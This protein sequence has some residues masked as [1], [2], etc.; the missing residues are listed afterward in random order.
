MTTETIPAHDPHPRKRVAVH[1]AEMSYIDVGE[2]DPVVF[3]HGNPTSSYFWRNVIPHVAPAARCLAPDLIG[4]GDSD[5]NP[6]GSYRFADHARFLDGWF[7]ALGL[8]RDVT[9]VLHDWGSILGFD[10]ACRHPTRIKGLVYMEAVVRPL[11]WDEWPAHT[12]DM[13]RQLRVPGAEA[14]AW[15]NM[16]IVAGFLH[17]GTRRTLSEDELAAYCRPFLQP[18]PRRL[19]PTT[20]VHEIPIGGAPADVCARTAAYAEW[21]PRS[22]VPKL[23][24]NAEPGLNLVGAQRAFCRAWPNQREVTVEGIHFLAEDC[25]EALGQHVRQFLHELG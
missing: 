1:G 17:L 15:E 24:V 21:L 3:L 7:D 18:G 14:L 20:F 23:F 6:E 8:D 19:P 22:P 13:I 12:R 9:L 25:P 10:W 4:M 11:E 16:G 2:G 5:L